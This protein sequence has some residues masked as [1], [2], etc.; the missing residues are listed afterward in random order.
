METSL[1]RLR[2]LDRYTITMGPGETGYELT[3]C[4]HL[5]QNR[6]KSKLTF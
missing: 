6:A 2:R 4:I 5:A 3:D 1:Q